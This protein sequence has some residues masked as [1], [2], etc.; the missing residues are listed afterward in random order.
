MTIKEFKKEIKPITLVAL[1]R[2]N[3]Y[4][5]KIDQSVKINWKYNDWVS[6]GVED[7]IACY[8]SGSVLEGDISIALNIKNLK[9]SVEEQIEK[10]I[11]TDLYTIM[12]ETI[13]TSVFHEMGHGIMEMFK[14]YIDY[15]DDDELQWYYDN[16]ELFDE[17]IDNEEDTVE[18][19]AWDFYDN[20]F[21]TNNTVLNRMVNVYLQCYQNSTNESQKSINNLKKQI[22][23]NVLNDLDKLFKRKLK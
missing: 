3:E 2:S 19:F 15:C 11:F 13:Q 7:A 4:L 17:A 12:D 1:E 9:K 18:A 22:F 23:E 21:E 5:K 16:Q 8:E 10:Y 20:D 14:D 6:R